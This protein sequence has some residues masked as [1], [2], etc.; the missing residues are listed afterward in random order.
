ML[1][2]QLKADV[3]A[4]LRWMNHAQPG[5]QVLPLVGG[6]LRRTEDQV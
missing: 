5:E 3:T 2:A 1:A 6:K 4:A